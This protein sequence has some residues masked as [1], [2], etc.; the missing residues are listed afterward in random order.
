MEEAGA[1]ATRLRIRSARAS[2]LAA[3]GSIRESSIPGTRHCIREYPV[4]RNFQVKIKNLT[5]V[6]K[7][8]FATF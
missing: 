6:L 4:P 2:M 3:R 5:H 8:I 1:A 7:N